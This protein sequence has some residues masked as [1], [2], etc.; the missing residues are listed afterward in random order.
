MT[1]RVNCTKGGGGGISKS[2]DLTHFSIGIVQCNNDLV[3]DFVEDNTCIAG[4]N[5]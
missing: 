3:I 5:Y 2:F 1:L 4:C